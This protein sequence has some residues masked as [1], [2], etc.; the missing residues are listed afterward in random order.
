MVFNNMLSLNDVPNYSTWFYSWRM[1]GG[2]TQHG[3]P[4]NC[5]VHIILFKS[6][7]TLSWPKSVIFFLFFFSLSACC[8]PPSPPQGFLTM[9]QFLNVPTVT[10]LVNK[11]M[12]I[13]GGGGQHLLTFS[14]PRKSMCSRKCASPGMSHGSD[15]DPT[16]DNHTERNTFLNLDH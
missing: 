11:P 8:R 3:T 9:P 2:T 4:G 7:Q 16:G 5:V 12:V 15:R 6:I 10:C 14:V 13:K 1:Q